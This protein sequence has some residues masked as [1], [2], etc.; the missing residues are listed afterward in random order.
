[1]KAT[2]PRTSYGTT[3]LSGRTVLRTLTIF[4]LL[5]ASWLLLA[6]KNRKI[7]NWTFKQLV[8]YRTK[9]YVKKCDGL[10]GNHSYHTHD[11]RFLGNWHFIYRYKVFDRLLP[12]SRPQPPVDEKSGAPWIDEYEKSWRAAYPGYEPQSCFVRDE[13]GYWVWVT[14]TPQFDRGWFDKKGWQFPAAW[15]TGPSQ[16]FYKVG[17]DYLSTIVSLPNKDGTTSVPKDEVW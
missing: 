10:C 9:L 11:L 2:S 12:D 15:I 14:N 13:K 4:S 3:R 1:M 16:E 17:A 7:G 5:S 6:L 8:K